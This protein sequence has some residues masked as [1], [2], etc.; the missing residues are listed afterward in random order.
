MIQST[1]GLIHTVAACVALLAGAIIFFRTKG[2][3]LHR[4]IGYGYAAAMLTVLTTAFLIHRLTGA[5]NALHVFAVLAT[6]PLLIGISVAALRRPRN[7][8]VRAHYYWMSWS[9]TG[10]VAAFSAEMATRLVVPYCVRHF[11]IRSPWIFWFLIFAMTGMVTAVG[12]ILIRRNESLTKS[13]AARRT[14]T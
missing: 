4:V 5:F 3:A 2:T 11:G 9:Y 12:A 6:P 14:P 10:L 8:W 1:T 7:G 13:I